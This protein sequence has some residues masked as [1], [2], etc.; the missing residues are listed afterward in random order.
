[1]HA[2]DASSLIHAW[3]NYP[4]GKFPPLWNWIADQIQTGTF[5]VSEVA[6][7]EV[8]NKAPECAGWLSEQGIHRLPLSNEIL[9]EAMRI[10]GMLGI[11]DDNYHSKG[12]GE[13]DLLIIATSKIHGLPLV[14][15]E[16]KQL[17]I[18]DVLPKC[19]I[20]TVCAFAGVN[21]HCIKFIELIKASDEVFH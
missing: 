11:V 21:V 4:L 19:K 14:S 1:M 5:V 17:R 7:Q 9:Q 18:P 13:N 10:K 12:V 15:D 16:G 20:P 8:H 6:F 3:D 2:F